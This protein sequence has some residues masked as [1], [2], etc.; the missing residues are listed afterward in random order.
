[1]SLTL[2]LVVAVSTF[3]GLHWA[4]AKSA[5]QSKAKRTLLGASVGTGSYG[6][7]S[8]WTN[9]L[10]V[11]ESSLQGDLSFSGY[12]FASGFFALIGVWG[13]NLFS[14]RRYLVR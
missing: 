7:F 3:A 12:F 10:S 4:S 8:E 13:W 2:Y 6:I 14:T 9:T 11:L 5:F 1:M